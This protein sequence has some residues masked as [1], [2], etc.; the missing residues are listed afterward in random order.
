MDRGVAEGGGPRRGTRRRIEEWQ[1]E[2]KITPRLAAR[3]R[4]RRTRST[5]VARAAAK[6]PP[7]SPRASACSTR[8]RCRLAGP[9][10][11]HRCRRSQVGSRR[12][13]TVGR[14]R[15]HAGHGPGAPGVWRHHAPADSR[16]LGRR[17]AG[18]VRRARRGAREAPAPGTPS[19]RRRGAQ[20]AAGTG[21]ARRAAQRSGLGAGS[22][23]GAE[24]GGTVPFGAD[25]G[26]PSGPAPN[27]PHAIWCARV[28]GVA[29]PWHRAAA[30]ATRRGAMG[31]PCGAMLSVL[32]SW[33][34]SV[35]GDDGADG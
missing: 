12:W 33:R 2:E 9:A 7:P 13:G 17:G 30:R 3:S 18:A 31:R 8:A 26:R 32:A 19:T 28:P 6:R 22:T 16:T 5:A 29:A 11:S 14:R 20:T 25:Q 4:A 23:A 35:G 10:G 15:R 34:G 27:D 21:A 24:A 1:K